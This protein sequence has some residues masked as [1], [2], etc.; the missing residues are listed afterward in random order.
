MIPW[1]SSSAFSSLPPLCCRFP[2]VVYV[3]G[4]IF[5]AP[6]GNERNLSSE[7]LTLQNTSD[8]FSYIS[9]TYSGNLVTYRV[10]WKL[11][12]YFKHKL[13]II[14]QC[15]Y[16]YMFHEISMKC[17]NETLLTCTTFVSF[18]KFVSKGTSKST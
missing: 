7:I 9:W 10:I 4:E 2:C 11:P 13:R 12:E 16:P 14:Y 17:K 15:S 1:I 3:A 5:S 8:A 6:T 18:S